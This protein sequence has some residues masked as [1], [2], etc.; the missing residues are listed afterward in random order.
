[1][2]LLS[3]RWVLLAGIVGAVSASADSP[4]NDARSSL[5]KWVET[6]QTT[7]KTKADWQSDREMLGQNIL[8]FE[9]ELKS[10]EEQIGKIGTGNSQADKERVQTESALKA[11]KEALDKAGIFAAELESG[12]AKLV[13]RLPVPLQEILKPLLN[14][15]PAGSAG[16]R[17]PA[18][19]RIQVAVGI[20]GEL[21][22]FNNAVSIFSEKRRN[23]QQEEV[24]V[25]TVYVGLGAAYFVNDAGDLAGT[26]APEAG[27]WEW[28]LRAELAPTVREVIRI[29]R[30]EQPARFVALPATIR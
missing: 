7:S 26:G 24:A 12:I 11:S 15:L 17:M 13:P 23:A 28:T 29:Y 14:R 19:E 4:L 21:D 5:E 8:L 27:G 2:H 16:T 10:V 9:R 22:K 6:H 1:M 3:Q 30:N 25:Q 20:L 18:T